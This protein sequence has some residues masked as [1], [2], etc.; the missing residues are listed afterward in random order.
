MA[1]SRAL[2][3]SDDQSWGTPWEFFNKLDEEFHFTIDVCA[4]PESAKCKRFYTKYDDGLK[5]DWTGETVFCNPPYGAKRI[6]PWLK[7]AWE[8]DALTVF[9]L[10]S[11]TD[12]IWFH[13]YL[14][15]KAEIRFIKSRLKFMASSESKYADRAPFGSIVAIIDNRNKLRLLKEMLTI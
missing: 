11:R 4:T 3:S 9:L 13:E 14:Y 8:E 1:I 12:T 5:Q 10:P 6:I 2:F 7:K 15:H